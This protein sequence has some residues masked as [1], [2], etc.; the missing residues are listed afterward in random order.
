M[1]TRAITVLS[2]SGNDDI[3]DSIFHASEPETQDMQFSQLS[4]PLAIA[5]L[6]RRSF[7]SSLGIHI[8]IIALLASVRS[9]IH[10]PE[11]TEVLTRPSALTVLYFKP[12]TAAKV[13]TER[14]TDGAFRTVIS[15]PLAAE[16]RLFAAVPSLEATPK[17]S[18]KVP[19]QPRLDIFTGRALVET[20][21]VTTTPRLPIPAGFT[22]ARHPSPT[23]GAGGRRV[24]V[25]SFSSTTE[26]FGG[27]NLPVRSEARGAGFPGVGTPN[28]QLPRRALVPSDMPAFEKAKIIDMPKPE[29]TG[30]ARKMGIQG[31]VRLAVV[32]KADGNVIVTG[33]THSLGFGLD[34]NAVAAVMRIRFQPARRDGKE[35]VDQ[36]G[37]VEA[38]FQLSYRELK[39]DENQVGG[40]QS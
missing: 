36:P 31:V 35:N 12:K 19:A 33:I 15:P 6:Q 25:G 2:L 28:P 29:Y 1:L 27:A 39:A 8:A 26:S 7:L 9:S 16:P 40:G 37:V 11:K 20:S 23:D 24:L 30:L 32:F 10:A 13:L 34:E 22:E 4:Y 21:T 38:V 14:V 18:A 17:K 5:Q 3:L